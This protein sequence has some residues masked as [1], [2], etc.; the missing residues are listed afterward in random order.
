MSA[1]SALLDRGVSAVTRACASPDAATLFD[2]LSRCLRTMVGF[3]SAGWYG[4]DPA[5]LLPTAPVRIEN[6]ASRPTGD[7][8]A[9]WNGEFLIED[10]TPFRTLARARKPAAALYAATDGNPTRSTRYRAF[11]EPQG[12][13]DELRAA[14]RTGGATWGVAALYRR[15][16]RPPFSAHDVTLV[17]NMAPVVG[18]ALRSLAL[19]EGSRAT[20]ATPGTVIYD[21][22]GR[23]RSWDEPA[24]RWFRELLGP[25][26]N[27]GGSERVTI[28]KAV[29]AQARAVA[30]GRDRRP[31]RT[32]LRTPSG[33]WLVIHASCLRDADGNLTDTA[34]VVEPAKSSQIAPIIIE[35]YG[36][37]AREQ[38]ITQAVARGLSNTEIAGQLHLSTH[39]VR[40]HLKAVF[41][42]VDVSSRGE[43]V[44]KLFADHYG[45]ML[46]AAEGD[47]VIHSE[48]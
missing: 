9:F 20:G 7:C 23:A 48:F 41:T 15:R 24:E 34:L 37:T 12:Y 44:A 38:E 3:D 14:F 32:R 29:L 40:D 19:S 36:L 43:L 21:A 6:F 5:T 35:A 8:D 18:A 27:R 16:G 28:V 17:A 13:D 47:G 10:V 33:Q 45:P 30:T 42:K 4:T 26:W 25:R 31:A 11:I 46:H 2:S 1:N 39:T 22:T